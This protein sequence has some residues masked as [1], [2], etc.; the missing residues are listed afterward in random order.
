MCQ[1][2]PCLS[3]K[4]ALGVLICATKETFRVPSALEHLTCG[5]L[6][7]CALSLLNAVKQTGNATG[8]NNHGASDPEPASEPG[9]NPTRFNETC[10][11]EACCSTSCGRT[12]EA[13]VGPAQSSLD[14]FSCPR[15]QTDIF[16]RKILPSHL[17]SGGE[18]H[19]TTRCGSG[20]GD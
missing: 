6:V 10:F 17:G 19:R 7:F 14:R 1:I 9:R 2:K 15:D 18:R 11:N 3:W 16:P 5:M 8:T 12:T 4:V 20:D 13:S